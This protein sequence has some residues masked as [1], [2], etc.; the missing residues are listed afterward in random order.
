MPLCIARLR[1]GTSALGSF[2]ET[3]IALT[4]CWVS[5][6]MKGTCWAAL[7]SDGPTCLNFPPRS[8]A[9]CW[10]PLAAV[11]KYGLLTALGR[12][13]MSSG[14]LLPL[15]LPE[16]LPPPDELSSPPHAATA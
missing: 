3:T 5:V 8:V 11:S 9:A 12:N 1:E 13:A 4:P 7:A 14:L 2:A 15:E 6:L 10:A 16:A